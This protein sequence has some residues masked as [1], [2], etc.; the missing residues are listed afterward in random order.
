MITKLDKIRANPIAAMSIGEEEATKE[1]MEE[2]GRQQSLGAGS[3]A[4]LN[5]EEQRP[6]RCKKL[7]DKVMCKSGA[8]QI[9][10]EPMETVVLEKTIIKIGSLLALGFGEAGAEIIGQNMTGKDS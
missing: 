3:S 10:P 8:P 5:E 2:L 4:F 7:L 9:A 1:A 6:S